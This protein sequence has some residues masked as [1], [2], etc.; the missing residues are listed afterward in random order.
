MSAPEDTSGEQ[1]DI[2]T[3]GGKLSSAVGMGILGAWESVG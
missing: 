2:C 1:L 3:K